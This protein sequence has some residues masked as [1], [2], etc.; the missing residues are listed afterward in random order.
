[1]VES[2]YV[3][4]IQRFNTL[5]AERTCNCCFTPSSRKY[6]GGKVNGFGTQEQQRRWQESTVVGGRW[7]GGEPDVAGIVSGFTDYNNFSHTHGGQA[8]VGA[9][10]K[11]V[12]IYTDV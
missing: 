9:A 1:M 10:C 6:I 7:I 3:T 5:C 4:G 2:H 12:Q 11:M 8:L